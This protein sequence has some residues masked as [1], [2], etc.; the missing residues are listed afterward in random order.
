[1]CLLCVPAFG[2]F[3]FSFYVRVIMQVALFIAGVIL[4]VNMER[5]LLCEATAS[6]MATS[7][8]IL[9]LRTVERM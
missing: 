6:V 9:G 7:F 3:Y 4:K 2:V 5:L 8:R 1:M